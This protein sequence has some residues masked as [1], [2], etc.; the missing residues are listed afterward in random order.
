MKIIITEGQINNLIED[1]LS[2]EGITYKIRYKGKS[3]GSFDANKM[4]DNVVFRFYYPN[5]DEYERGVSFV[6][7]EDEIRRFS[8]ASI[9]SDAISELKYIPSEV[10]NDYFVNLAEKYLEELFDNR[11]LY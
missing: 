10:V 5:G 1:I 9:F 3:Y 7:K 11:P 6:T 2:Y 8:G 4:Y